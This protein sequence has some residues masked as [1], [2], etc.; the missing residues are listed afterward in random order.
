MAA[1]SSEV[2]QKGSRIS[3]PMNYRFGCVPM[4]ELALWV[5]AGLGLGRSVTSPFR[6][7][8]RSI[9]RL[10]VVHSLLQLGLELRR[11]F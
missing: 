9:V 7:E 5:F 11:R 8:L 6:T 1:R 4:V 3:G 10:S 2:V